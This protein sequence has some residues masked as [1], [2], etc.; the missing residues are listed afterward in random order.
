MVKKGVSHPLGIVVDPNMPAFPPGGIMLQVVQ[1]N[2]QGGQ[3]LSQLGYDAVYNDD[4]A[5]LW[6]GIGPQ[7]DGL[8]H[9][10][11]GGIYYNCNDEKDFAALTGLAK[12][13][14]DQIPSLIGRGVM[15]DMAKHFGMEVLPAGH[16]FNADDVEAAAEAQVWRFAKARRG[17]V[18]HGLDRWDARVR[19]DGHLEE[20]CVERPRGQD[21]GEDG[22]GPYGRCWIGVR[23]SRRAS[24]DA[25]GSQAGAARVANQTRRRM[26]V[27]RLASP[28]LVVARARP[29]ERMTR[30]SRHF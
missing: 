9:F 29:T 18:P 10:A 8:G 4:I 14:V 5:Q 26:L 15:I 30:P 12:L 20:P 19:S 23:R 27:T 6:F 3:R 11:E 25:A 7:I 1:P 2:Q 21:L 24:L 28:S 16:A 17:A 22:S 13:S